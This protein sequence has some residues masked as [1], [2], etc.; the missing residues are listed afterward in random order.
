MSNQKKYKQAFSTLH[1]SDNF[2]LE[3]EKMTMMKK[4]QL[5]KNIAAA[6]AICVL[7][8]GV[9]TTAYAADLGGIQRK[10]QLWIYGDLTDV[11]LEIDSDGSYDMQYTDADG[12]VQ[13]RGGGGVAFNADGTERPLTEEEIMEH[14]N[15]P[16]V[17]Y[18]D[19]G[20][21]WVYYYDQKIEITD[22]FEDGVCYVK[23]SAGD[24]TVYMTVKYQNGYAM[25]ESSYISPSHFNV[26]K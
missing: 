22:K 2:S 5:F 1:A 11:S 10:I 16:E 19:D 12:N 25:S 24:K 20:T 13:E 18:E 9:G 23:L 4:K 6:V 14:L 8:A 7:L 21:V 26:K 17:E 15:E 3:V